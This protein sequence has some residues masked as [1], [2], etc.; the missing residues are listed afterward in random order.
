MRDFAEDSGTAMFS[1]SQTASPTKDETAHS[2]P[3]RFT[4][5]ASDAARKRSAKR[6]KAVSLS[7][8]GPK[9]CLMFKAI[10]LLTQ[11]F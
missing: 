2:S 8:R 4:S 9:L 10:T 6:K 5:S 7:S 1:R 11:R 3:N